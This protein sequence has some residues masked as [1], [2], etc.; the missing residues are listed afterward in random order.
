MGMTSTSASRSSSSGTL[1][2][3]P[4]A[5]RMLSGGGAARYALPGGMLMTAG[6]AESTASA[7]FCPMRPSRTW[8][9]TSPL[10]FMAIGPR[11]C[12]RKWREAPSNRSAA[13]ADGE[14]CAVPI[15]HEDATRDAVLT[16]SP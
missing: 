16:V 15:S 11:S 12:V 5:M 1:G 14:S 9:V 13:M 6:A 4:G 10:P 7:F 2:S 8:T 3:A